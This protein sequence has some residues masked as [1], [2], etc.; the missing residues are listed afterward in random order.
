M[1]INNVDQLVLGKLLQITF[2]K[3]FRRQLVR[4]HRDWES[5]KQMTVGMPGGREHRFM[6]QVGGGP[7]AIQYAAIGASGAFPA[8]QR[9]AVEEKTAIFKELNAT[10][11]IDYMLF[12]RLKMAPAKYA[13]SLA[14]EL[15]DKLVYLKRRV[16]ADLYNDGLGVLGTVAADALTDQGVAQGKVGLT[17]S[18]VAPRGHIGWFEYDD[19]LVKASPAGAITANV[20]MPT[21]VAAWKVVS[22]DRENNKLVLQA[23]DAN[24]APVALANTAASLID[25]ADLLYRGTTAASH[26]RV[27]LTDGTPRLLIG[28]NYVTQDYGTA[29]EIIAGLGALVAND[30]RQVH[31]ITMG[32]VT[33]STVKDCGGQPIDVTFIQQALSQV[34]TAV[35]QG[36]YKYNQLLCAP[37]MLDSLIEGRETDRRFNSIEDATRGVRKFVYQHGEDAVEFVTSEFARKNEAIALPSGKGEESKCVEFIGTDF[38]TVEAPGSS[39]K[40]HLR[41]TS[42]GGHE[43][44]LVSYMFGLGVMV[45]QHPKACLKIKNFTNSEPA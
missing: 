28:G 36:R 17:I 5:V 8:A 4:D 25:S 3:G 39:S 21:G 40:F 13:D 23:I 37:E 45:N 41:P 44:K 2:S 31:G 22:I 26:S 15:E 16:A 43:K 9:S 19:L 33:G 32:G 20:E 34:K 35:G 24:G 6:F 14:M 1:A 10:I 42:G 18:A 11:E 29:T 38:K 30:G 12:E 27:D 7:A